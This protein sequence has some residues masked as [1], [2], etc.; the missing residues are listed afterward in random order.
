MADELNVEQKVDELSKPGNEAELESTLN[1]EFNEQ[2]S[3]DDAPAGGDNTPQNNDVNN[4]PPENQPAPEGGEPA[5]AGEPA[6]EGTGEPLKEGGEA[7]EGNKPNDTQDRFKKI[8]TSRN[9]AK[10][11]AAE[12][13]TD[14]QI[15]SKQVKDLTDLVQKLANGDKGE[16]QPKLEDLTADELKGKDIK[17][18][19]SEMLD[20]REANKT[21]QEA[22]EKS[23]I[24]EIKALETNPDTPNSAQYNEQIAEVM[25]KHTTLSAYAAYRL[26]QGEGIIPSEGIGTSNANKTGTGNRSKSGLRV[27]KSAKNMTVE[28]QEAHLRAEEK[29]GGLVGII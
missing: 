18:I 25:K 29:N 12:A 16:D 6:P 28:E 23:D 22:A 24:T 26:L 17:T 20:E 14:N 4:Q 15:L 21:S 10:N 7:G 27:N 8:L 19:L 9:E 2:T 11:E 1:N 13:Q 3:A 5:P